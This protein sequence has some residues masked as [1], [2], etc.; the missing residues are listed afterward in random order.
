MSHMDDGILH[1]FLDGETPPEGAARLREHLASCAECRARL[2]VAREVR[3]RAHE[4]LRLADPPGIVVPDFATVAARGRSPAAASPRPRRRPLLLPWAASVLLALGAGWFAQELIRGQA[5]AGSER[6]ATL[7][8]RG[9]PD[10]DGAAAPAGGRRVEMRQEAGREMEMVAG[11]TE[12]DGRPEAGRVAAPSMALETAAAAEAAPPP[13]VSSAARPTPPAATAVPSRRGRGDAPETVTTGAPTRRGA[14]A[15]STGA[16]GNGARGE[17]RG[18]LTARAEEEAKREASDLAS[19]AADVVPEE[20]SI[21]PGAAATAPA[22]VVGEPVAVRARDVPAQSGQG[23]RVD[24]TAVAR[25]GAVSAQISRGATA[26]PPPLPAPAA[27]D[28][29]GWPRE[30]ITVARAA[31]TQALTRQPAVVAGIPVEAY[32][33]GGGAG[34]S[35]RVLQILPGGELLEILQRRST[36]AT[37]P[38]ATFL[39]PAAPTAVR[40][41]TAAGAS[42]RLDGLELL[43]RAEVSPDSLRRLTTELR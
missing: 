36:A 43:I 23:E 26:P 8:D 42:L 1:T 10:V 11:E 13:P 3:T 18:P 7:Q 14:G 2:D 38:D 39:S 25:S 9:E 22:Q 29:G 32:Q 28:E 12:L 35:V 24:P 33:L 16:A 6:V 5:E 20:Q 30:W 34:L 31:A 17:V 37:P 4:I 40:F 15:E 27:P 41:D 19:V 21:V